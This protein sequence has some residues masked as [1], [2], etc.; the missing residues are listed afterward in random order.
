MYVI[1]SEHE[2]HSSS[3]VSIASSDTSTVIS[4]GIFIFYLEYQ[5]RCYFIIVRVYLI[6][7]GV[8]GSRL[9]FFFEK[10]SEGREKTK[11]QPH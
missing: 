10:G 7:V 2:D 11:S 6:I 1:V 9:N 3:T 5:Y 4:K 8:I